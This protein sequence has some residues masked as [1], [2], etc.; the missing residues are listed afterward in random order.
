MPKYIDVQAPIAT[1]N[2]HWHSRCHYKRNSGSTPAGMNNLHIGEPTG[3]RTPG[4][5]PTTFAAA[6][7]VL[8]WTLPSEGSRSRPLEGDE[9]Q[10]LKPKSRRSVREWR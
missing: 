8:G 9:N 5:P 4:D 7:M 2:K 1:M 3:R 10:I 6:A